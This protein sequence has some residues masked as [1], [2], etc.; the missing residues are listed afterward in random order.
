K[1]TLDQ[2]CLSASSRHA[3]N[4]YNHLGSAE[5]ARNVLGIIEGRSKPNEL[6]VRSESEDFS[7]S[8][9]FLRSRFVFLRF[10]SASGF[11]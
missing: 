8:G 4:I 1:I 5:G 10:V 11:E 3:K 9:T 2:D 6:V 7:F